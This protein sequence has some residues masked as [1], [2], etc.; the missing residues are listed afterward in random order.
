[1]SITPIL[2]TSFHEDR[3]RHIAD[4]MTVVLHCHH[5]ASLTTQL[6]NDCSFIDAKKLL[7][8]CA[9]DAFYN[10]LTDYYHENNVTSIR[11][12]I[13]AG[14][15]YFSECGLGKMKVNFAG[16]YSG[17]AKLM[18]SHVD[19]GW[20]KKWGA[21]HEPVNHIGCGFVTALFSSVFDKPVRTYSAKEIQSI[22]CGA[23]YSIISVS[24]ETNI[25]KEGN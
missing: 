20:V 23:D 11:E 15:R 21:A 25:D 2:Q 24:D 9:E 16:L 17:E 13:H 12:R 6:A 18:H 5:F 8:E 14:E 1:M 3:S 10:V 4:G 22:V 19:E 7:A